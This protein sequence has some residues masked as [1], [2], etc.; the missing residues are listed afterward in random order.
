LLIKSAIIPIGQ[1]PDER[2]PRADTCFFNLELP[3]YTSLDVLRRQLTRGINLSSDMDGDAPQRG[4][5]PG[6]D[7]EE[8]EYDEEDDEEEM[9]IEEEDAAWS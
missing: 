4:L 3:A 7:E 1:S 8:M 9:D 5:G 6:P 2:F